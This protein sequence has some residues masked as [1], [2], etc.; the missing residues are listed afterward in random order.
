MRSRPRTSFRW[1][2]IFCL[3]RWFIECLTRKRTNCRSVRVSWW[4][5]NFI[6]S[7]S[8]GVSIDFPKWFSEHTSEIVRILFDRLKWFTKW[9]PNFSYFIV[10]HCSLVGMCYLLLSFILQLSL[11]DRKLQNEHTKKWSPHKETEY[12][13][14]QLLYEPMIIMVYLNRSQV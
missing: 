1:A 6:S 12:T 8:F 10:L 5:R 7:D 4:R 14:R 2:K 3:F 13:Q 11:E 9:L